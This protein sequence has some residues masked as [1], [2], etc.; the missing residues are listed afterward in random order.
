M[1]ISSS[2]LSTNVG[3]RQTATPVRTEPHPLNVLLFGKRPPRLI[4]PRRH[5]KVGKGLKKLE[6]AKD[7]IAELA[8]HLGQELSIALCEGNNACISRDGQIAFGVE[9]LEHHQD[10]DDL[11]MAIL[12]HEIGHQP[13]FWPEGDLGP[14]TQKQ[15]DALFREEEAKA[16]RFAGR[17][18]ADLKAD[19]KA[20]GA[21][22]KAHAKFEAAKP[23][24]Y[25]P[26]DVRAEMIAKAFAQRKTDL[27]SRVLSPAMK[28]RMSE[29]R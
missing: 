27:E 6:H 4:D 19:P 16:D 1:K 9:L 24:D 3:L 23:S 29:L 2:T 14:M 12:G 10:N 7:Q 25:Y 28:R 13:W 15:L 21:F 8:G 11:M 17:V 18:L 22:L 20:I 26:A 5:P